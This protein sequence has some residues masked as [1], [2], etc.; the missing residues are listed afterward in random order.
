M[1]QMSQMVS[2]Q[3]VER[4]DMFVHSRF[5]PYT[6]SGGH[7]LQRACYRCN[8]QVFPIVCLHC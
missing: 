6:F 1:P 5:I 8:W 7:G 2:I 3:R 4:N